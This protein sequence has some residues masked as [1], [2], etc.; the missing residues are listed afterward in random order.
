MS[1]NSK[2]L[3]G[4]NAEKKSPSKSRVVTPPHPTHVRTKTSKPPQEPQN[5]PL[6]A[7]SGND[8][9]PPP[10]GGGD[11]V[12]RTMEVLRHIPVGGGW[13][14]LRDGGTSKGLICMIPN[15]SAVQND[16]VG[17]VAERSWMRNIR[18]KNIPACEMLVRPR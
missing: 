12:V 10:G 18:I 5:W 11:E 1:E 13:A 2:I 6:M 4:C 9:P 7:G 15:P 17:V 16:R 14:L 3:T 8:C